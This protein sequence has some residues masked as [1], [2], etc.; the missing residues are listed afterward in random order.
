MRNKTYIM[1]LVGQLGS[2]SYK[3]GKARREKEILEALNAAV[4]LNVITTMKPFA[5]AEKKIR[6][7]EEKIKDLL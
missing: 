2:V 1:A 4:D 3:Y 7:I 5:E 6:E